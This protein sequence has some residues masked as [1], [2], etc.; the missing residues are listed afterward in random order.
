MSTTTRPVVSVQELRRAWNAVQDGQF[1]SR[2]PCSSPPSSTTTGSWTPTGPTLTVVGAT[3]SSGASTTALALATA[4]G[5]ARLIEC[6]TITASSLCAAATAELGRHPSGWLQGR[7]DEVLIERCSQ[8]L[9]GP[10]EVPLPIQ[11]ELPLSV[12]DIGWELGQV[13]GGSSW[14]AEHLLSTSTVIVVAPATVPGLRRLEGAAALLPHTRVIAAV[15]GPKRR[16]WPREVTGALGRLTAA[17]DAG[18]DL[19]EVPHETALAVRGMDST[20]LPAPL[21]SWAAHL[22][23]HA[24]ATP[25]SKGHGR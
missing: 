19:L 15:L 12:V 25:R 14:L 13:L 20:P 1:R 23:S 3:G 9:L 22:L 7:R 24:G 21:I 4:A 11:S 2:R 10:T 8:V 18:G 17:I 5:P 6:A 16:R